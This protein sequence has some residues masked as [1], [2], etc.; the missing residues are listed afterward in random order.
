MRPF[1]I[2]LLTS[3]IAVSMAGFFPAFAEAAPCSPP[4]SGDW[5]VN[6]TVLC[7]GMSFYLNGS[8]LVNS[9]GNL[10][11]QD[12]AVLFNSS[13]D[14]QFGVE[15]NGSLYLMGALMN[16]STGGAY[17]F[18]SNAGA[19]L[20]IRNSY[21]Y[22]CGFQ[23]SDPRKTG[24][25]SASA[26]TN[27]TNTTF[28][29][30]YFGLTI[31]AGNANVSGNRFVSSTAGA[32]SITGSNAVFANNTI[33]SIND[34]CSAGIMSA[35]MQ[36]NN[37]QVK[38]NSFFSGLDGGLRIYGNANNV[39][40]NN[41]AYSCNSSASSSAIGGLGIYGSD[42]IVAGNAMVGNFNTG[43]EISSS[44]NTI[45]TGNV[46]VGNDRGLYVL[47]SRNT[48]VTNTLCNESS[49][50]DVFLLSSSNV[51]LSN[52]NYTTMLRGWRFDA[53]VSDAS[54]SPVPGAEVLLRNSYGVTIYGGTTN[55]TGGIPLPYLDDRK[56]N[57]SGVFVFSPYSVNVTKPGY[58]GN[59]TVFN[60]TADTNMNL[61]VVSNAQTIGFPLFVNEPKNSTYVKSNLTASGMMLFSVGSTANI[62]SCNLTI[63]M[64]S[65]IIVGSMQ[66]S[67]AGASS[68]QTLLNVSGL[69]GAYKVVFACTSLDNST[70][71]TGIVFSVFPSFECSDS[72][73]CGDTQVCT[74]SKCVSL[75]CECGFAENHQC[76][77]YGCCADTDCKAEETCNLNTHTCG[78]VPCEC[79]E[80]RSNHKCSMEAGYCC[81]DLQC[82]ENEACM[83][84][85][86]IKR[87][88]FFTLPEDLVYG[89]NVTVKV[90]DQ[91]GN[92]V[93]S[94]HVE[95]KYLDTDPFVTDTY[96][97]DST[98]VALVE[99]THAGRVDLV[100]RKGGYFAGD[101]LG[102]VPE[103]FNYLLLVEI[104]VLIAAFA[105]IAVVGLKLIKKGGGK[106]LSFGEG[107]MRLEKS[108]SGT[109]VMLHLLNK[110]KKKLE[111]ITIRDSVP[112]GAFIQCPVNPKVSPI[113]SSTSSLTWEI[114]QLKPG[115][116]VTIEY[117]TYHANKG[118]SVMYKGK[119]YV[120]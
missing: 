18:V 101:S 56:E 15:S 58:A 118:F 38:N 77:E 95:V 116:E 63:N 100:A 11:L 12:T 78:V 88:L 76:T 31:N 89:T 37:S 103:P 99:I 70:N 68:F 32:I 25:Y 5:V 75:V 79:P 112:A 8:L 114:L 45:V 107:P 51:T 27:V 39:A 105:G 86:C 97:T 1:L 47:S 52:V 14:G 43:L 40:G 92:P 46:I 106:G 85:A 30:N 119:E 91:D 113:D 62:S 80:K 2:A 22:S 111:G 42:N 60:A 73:G 65:S 49:R 81:R 110:T 93:E 41:I 17:Y 96:Y 108:V 13:F 28:S 33:G 72:A 23:S 6:D 87:A 34:N 74:S 4:T 3:I 69:A 20:E 50:Y 82:G 98:G 36:A 57:Q 24:V 66:P 64:T 84:N 26:W 48:I 53:R 7:T 83:N 44:Q 55:S 115:E 117:E 61:V 21:I 104:V 19:N 102:E 90:T 10:T 67:A 59:Y 35:Q 71:S 94:V 120:G 54:G 109:S 16:K 9:S 29:K